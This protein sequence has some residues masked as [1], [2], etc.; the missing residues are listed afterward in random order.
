MKLNVIDWAVVVLVIIGAINWGVFAIF[1]VDIVA[2]ILGEGARIVYALVG[3]SGIYMIFTV[4]KF[5]K[6]EDTSPLM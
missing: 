5:G 3:I 4:M 6:V 2:P 1:G